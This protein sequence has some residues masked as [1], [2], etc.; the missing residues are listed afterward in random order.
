MHIRKQSTLFKAFFLLQMDPLRRKRKSNMACVIKFWS[1]FGNALGD[2]W[3]FCKHRPQHG[4][5][6]LTTQ[7]LELSS[8]VLATLLAPRWS[9]SATNKRNMKQ[10]QLQDSVIVIGPLFLAHPH[11][12]ETSPRIAV[13]Q[14]KG[15][16]R[17]E[18]RMSQKDGK[19]CFSIPIGRH[20][21]AL[22][23]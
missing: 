4:T 15:L 21:P 11:H 19:V 9:K 3:S 22:P 1:C 23:A 17:L 16:M 13:K 18:L 7:L 8:S 2:L 6:F 12:H 14:L 5:Y 10:L 20:A